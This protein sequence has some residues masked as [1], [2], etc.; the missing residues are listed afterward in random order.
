METTFAFLVDG[1][2]GVASADVVPVVLVL[3]VEQIFV[4]GLALQT[5]VICCELVPA[6]PAILLND[7][8]LRHSGGYLS[9]LPEVVE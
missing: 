9:V 7:F 6:Q 1:Y 4:L 2:Y 3:G 5:D 8:D